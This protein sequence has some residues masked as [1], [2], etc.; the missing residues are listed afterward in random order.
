[1][2]IQV[3]LC[4]GKSVVVLA[5]TTYWGR[6]LGVMLFKDAITGNNLHKQY[7]VTHETLLLY[8]QG[9]ESLKTRGLTILGIV[10]HGKKGLL[11]MYP[12]VP[13]QMCQFDQLKI[14]QRYLTRNPELE[15]GKKLWAL[16]ILL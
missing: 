13:T 3:S 16:T 5:D 8:R 1:M 15:A 14:I 12:D 4:L 11:H 6:G 9:F 7:C 10:C 2:K